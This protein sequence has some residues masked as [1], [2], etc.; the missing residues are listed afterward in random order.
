MLFLKETTQGKCACLSRS[1]EYAQMVIEINSKLKKNISPRC[2]PLPRQLLAC[3]WG[4]LSRSCASASET[5]KGNV[6]RA[7]QEALVL[8][9]DGTTAFAEKEHLLDFSWLVLAYHSP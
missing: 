1:R 8:S 9:V 3:W 5:V 7:V 4:G 6:Q 2:E